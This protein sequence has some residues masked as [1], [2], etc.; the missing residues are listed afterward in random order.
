MVDFG[1]SVNCFFY[2]KCKYSGK[3]SCMMQSQFSQDIVS[4]TCFID[5]RP[6][7]LY[8]KATSSITHFTLEY[9]YINWYTSDKNLAYLLPNLLQNLCHTVHCYRRFWCF[10]TTAGREKLTETIMMIHVCNSHGCGTFRG[11]L[12]VSSCLGFFS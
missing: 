2:K 3:C 11:I 9:V 1:S 12:F 6:P 5:Q 10:W 4:C 7:Q 8:Y